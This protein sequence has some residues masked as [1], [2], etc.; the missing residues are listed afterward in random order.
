MAN[1]AEIGIAKISLDSFEKLIGA[2]SKWRRSARLAKMQKAAWREMLKGE[3]GD[4]A[5]VEAAVLEAT[6]VGHNTPEAVRMSNHLAHHKSRTAS[7][8]KPKARKGVPKTRAK[9][10]TNRRKGDKN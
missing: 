4:W 7:K 8:S 5:V 6:R 3:S 10:R 2:L 1:G 9:K